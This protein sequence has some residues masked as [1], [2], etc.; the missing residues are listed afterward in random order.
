MTDDLMMFLTRLSETREAVERRPKRKGKGMGKGKGKEKQANGDLR[1]N[2]A[3][4]LEFYYSTS[5]LQHILISL[6][7]IGKPE[8]KKDL[9]RN[10]CK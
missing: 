7:R 10:L 8:L 4:K 6:D 1:E 2:R 9:A 3:L 5:L